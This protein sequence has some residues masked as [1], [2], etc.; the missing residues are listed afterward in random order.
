MKQE[1]NNNASSGAIY[2][3]GVVGAGIYFVSHA[4]SFWMG[5]FGIVKALVWP[6]I[7][8]YEGLVRMGL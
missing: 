2:G 4:T 5:V 8:V 3:L 6:A 7:M 1:I